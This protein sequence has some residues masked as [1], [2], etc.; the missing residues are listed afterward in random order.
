MSDI[1]QTSPAILF[2]AFEPS[3][4]DHAAPVIAQLKTLLPEVPIVAVGGPKMEAAGAK[5]LMH[6]TDNAVMGL[7]VLSQ[8]KHHKARLKQI[9]KFINEHP[10]ALHVP[11]DSP[12]A[13]WAICKMV[14]RRWSNA[15]DDNNQ[16]LGLVAHLVAPQVW[17]WASWRVRRLQKWSDHVMCLLP[18]EPDWFKSH[19][20]PATFIGHPVFE[21]QLNTS[22]LEEIAKSYPAAKHQ[23]ALLPGSRP[24][25]I[26]KNWPLMLETVTQLE[27]Q[28]P[29]DEIQ[30]VIA[31]ASEKTA[32]LIQETAP[33][34]S[35]IQ[36]VTG[37]TDV[38]IHWAHAV[39]VV[40]GTATLH[41]AR[42]HK[43]MTVLYKTSPV[44]WNLLGRF[45]IN[46][47]TF[48][49]PN[50]IAGQG[51]NQKKSDHIVP[52]FV[53]YLSNN[54]KPLVES[55][56][57]LITNEDAQLKQ[58]KALTDVAQIC[59]SKHAGHEATKVLLKLL[60]QEHV[61]TD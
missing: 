27:K 25:E 16:P 48:T 7:G 13:N 8:I 43:P 3:G 47:K 17:A 41:I 45:L 33:V 40:S 15:K 5:L 24:G 6:T 18:F 22:E 59:A 37:Q 4:D 31:G 58:V 46:T 11:T 28:F 9:Q 42:Q 34:P 56:Q 10:I 35:H 1:S 39:F 20:V 51:P 30:F 53:P 32:K 52:E 50:L 2:T 23:V 38:V 61:L 29:Q 60:N 12:A 44:V 54:P 14:K 36:L 49:L 57:H 26:R 19:N 21:D 55:L